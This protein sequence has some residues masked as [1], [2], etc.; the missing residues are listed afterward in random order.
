M[1]TLFFLALCCKCEI[2]DNN[3]NLLRF[4]RLTPAYNYWVPALL[5]VL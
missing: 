4:A 2:C 3:K 5:K 1:A